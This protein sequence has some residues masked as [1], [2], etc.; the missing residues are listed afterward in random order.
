MGFRKGSV[1]SIIMD[2]LCQLKRDREMCIDTLKEK[3]PTDKDLDKLVQTICTYNA[4]IAE[5]EH[6]IELAKINKSKKSNK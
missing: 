4:I 3:Y 6:V 5:F 1:G 2:S